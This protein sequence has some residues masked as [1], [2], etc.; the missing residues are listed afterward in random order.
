MYAAGMTMKLENIEPF[1][2]RFEKLVAENI[3]QSQLSP[4]I[5]VDSPISVRDID[6]KFCRILRQFQPF[7]PDN[8]APVFMARNLVSNGAI[9]VVGPKKE[10]L[11]MEVFSEDAHNH[12]FQAI[13]FHQAHHYKLI[14][15]G[16]PFDACF[17]IEENEFRGKTP[18]S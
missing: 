10:H 17:T 13:A 5:E 16:I 15:C 4:K 12:V 11:K 3:T 7:G 8:A 9:K 1:S 6:Q 18:G 14:S 2:K